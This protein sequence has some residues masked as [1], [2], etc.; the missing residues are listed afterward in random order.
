MY[1]NVMMVSSIPSTAT[2]DAASS[3]TP[4][5]RHTAEQNAPRRRGE[6]HGWQMIDHDDAKKIDSLP[7]DT[8]R[9][10]EGDCNK[11]RVSPWQLFST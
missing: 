5:S 2:L 8:T 6:K 1:F 3:L 10:E 11:T 4:S 7:A 9:P